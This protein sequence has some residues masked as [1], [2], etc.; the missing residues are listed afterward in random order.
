MKRR[1]FI[2]TTALAGLTGAA[3][4]GCAAM[5]RAPSAS[6][7]GFDLH[8]FVKANPD[9]VFIHRTS[10]ADKLDTEGIHDA[11]YQLSRELIVPVQSGGYPLSTRIT[12][13]PNWTSTRQR[14]HSPV[15]DVLG[16]NTDPHFMEGWMHAM[17]DNGSSEFFIRECASPSQ[18]EPMGYRAM[19][20]RNGFDL[21]DLSTKNFWEL[22]DGIN[23]IDIPDG[24]VF[25]KMGFMAPMNERGTFLVN[26]AKMK[27]HGM[28]ITASVKN[29]QGITG[30]RFHQFCTAYDKVRSGFE[31]QYRELLQDDFE[32]HIEQLYGA[33]V[34]MGLPRWGRPGDEGGIWQEQWVQ[35]MLDSYSVTPTGINIVEGNLQSGRQR[36]RQRPAREK[37]PPGSPAVIISRISWYSVSIHSV[38]T[39]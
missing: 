37:A 21:T 10:L 1:D 27:A 11:A 15:P 23:L 29:L 24:V 4:Q 35:R 18:W 17:R 13:K 32:T 25:K 12:V 7:P 20:D 22:G 14:D 6:G 26:I 9:A 34:K 3:A 8:P 36:L 19:A 28:G 16:V 5:G 30:R 33:H 2:K 31:P 38:W 39:S